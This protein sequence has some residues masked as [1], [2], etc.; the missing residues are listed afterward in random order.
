MWINENVTWKGFL[1][2]LMVFFIVLVIVFFVLLY[3]VVSCC[4]KKVI[5]VF[6]DKMKDDLAKNLKSGFDVAKGGLDSNALRQGEA[7]A[8]QKKIEDLMKKYGLS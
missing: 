1:I 8:A 4:L 6:Q 5:K 3:F 2:T 7:E